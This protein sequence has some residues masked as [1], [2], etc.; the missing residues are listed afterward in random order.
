MNGPLRNSFIVV[1]LMFGALVFATSWW[2]VFAAEDLRE[3]P[4]NRRALLEEERVKRGRILARDGEVLARPRAI[5][6][7]R[8]TRRYPAGE[9]FSHAIGYSYT[10]IGRAALEQS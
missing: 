4:Q 3:N 2:T 7:K 6:G 10:S 8:Y 1:L 5:A 9:L